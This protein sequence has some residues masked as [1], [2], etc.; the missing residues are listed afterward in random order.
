MEKLR[1]QEDSLFNE[2]LIRLVELHHGLRYVNHKRWAKV[3]CFEVD[4]IAT[5]ETPDRKLKR[6]IMFELKKNGNWEECIIQAFRRMTMSNYSYAVLE[7]PQ[8]TDLVNFMINRENICRMLREGVGVIAYIKSMG[9]KPIIL[10]KAKFHTVSNL[11][12]HL[13]EKVSE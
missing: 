6:I 3:Y 2:D 7:A 10:Y 8:L 13:I 12:E 5:F 1:Y 9:N 11:F 4:V